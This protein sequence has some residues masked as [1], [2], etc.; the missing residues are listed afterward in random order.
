MISSAFYM[1]GRRLS[2]LHDAAH[3]YVS[4]TLA[5]AFATMAVMYAMMAHLMRLRI[6]RLHTIGSA[7]PPAGRATP[8]VS[9]PTTVSIVVP[10]PRSAVVIKS[11]QKTAKGLR[12]LL[13]VTVVFIACWSPLCV[14]VCGLPVPS[15]LLY[16]FIVNS[17]INPF[18]YSFMSSDFRQDVRRLFR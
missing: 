11:Q 18:I 8:T 14:A 9:T 2:F 12:V 16:L 1:V 7:S 10:S 4:V 6:R 3:I 5:A 17:V 13:V 15:V